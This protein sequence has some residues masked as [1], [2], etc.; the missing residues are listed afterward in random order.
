[1]FDYLLVNGRVIDGTGKP[2]FFADVGI[3][4]DRIAA[5]GQLFHA[6]AKHRI[7]AMGKF[8]V[9]GFIDIHTHYDLAL[10]VHP[11]AYCAISQGVTTVVIGNCGHS[12]A[13]ISEERRTALRHLLPVIEAGVEWRWQRFAEFLDTLDEAK[14]AVNVV[15]LVGH[16]ALRA[17]VVGFDNRPATSE[18][19]AAMQRLLAASME[20][21][22]W[23]LSSGLIYPP[24]AFAPMDELV[25]L[26]QV[27]A[28]RNGIYAT[29]MRNESDALV[30]AVTEALQTAVRSSVR[31]QISHHKAARRPNWGKVAVTLPMIEKVALEHNVTVDAYPYTAGSANLSQL[32]PLWALEGGV[33]ALLARLRDPHERKRL[34]EALEADETLDWSAVLI[35][36][37]A[38][39]AYR[40]LQGKRV[41]E[42]A[43]LLGLPPAEAVLH[44]IEHERNAV[45]MVHFVMDERDV[46]RV[47]THPLCLVGSDALTVPPA[48]SEPLPR[49]YV[50]PRTYGT[51]P[52]VLRWL[53]KEKK[54]LKWEEAIAKMTGQTARKLNLPNRGL[55]REGYYADLV[56]IDP[57]RIADRSTYEEP[58][59]PAEGIEWVFVNGAPA[60]AN[61]QPTGQRCGRVLRFGAAN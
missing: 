16:C 11:D 31:L 32:L 17:A 49:P 5:I 60:I 51:F 18:E 19:L 40:P 13:P 12:P 45:T 22:A 36:S 8:I 7:D 14:P 39:E 43:Q 24:S 15:A 1:M 20:E 29:H 35:A 48:P 26:A 46:E 56:V 4:G 2:P 6:P 50:H 23:G 27:V 53:V 57:E 44:L 28:Q 42:A 52:K 25:A 47:L 58:H 3:Q 55:V 33:D 54:A 34:R 10:L 21:G 61:E 38:S 9:P 41:T 59:Q 30:T 37:V